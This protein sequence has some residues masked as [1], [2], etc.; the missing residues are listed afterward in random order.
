MEETA[1]I[2]HGLSPAEVLRS[3]NKFGFNVE[4]THDFTTLKLIIRTLFSVFNIVMLCLIIILIVIGESSIAK[5]IGI[6]AG[7][8]TLIGLVQEI[9]ARLIVKKLNKLSEKTTK[10]V[11]ENKITE[12]PVKELVIGDVIHLS[13]GDRVPVDGE[14]ISA[15]YAEFDESILTGES[16]YVEKKKNDEIK[17]GSFA[18]A[19]SCN[20]TM[21]KFT[22]DSYIQTLTKQITSQGI[23]ES[24][25][26]S[27]MNDIIKAL[28][29]MTI[30]FIA[31][32]VAEGF[33]QE[34]QIQEIIINAST[35]VSSL[36]P[37]GLVLITTIS[38]AY[39]AIKMA[40]NQAIIQNLSS[41]ES[42]ANAK[43]VCMDKTGTLT[44]NVLQVKDITWIKK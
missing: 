27:Q 10:V 35:L 21:T 29:Y 37:Q 31:L 26:Q 6:I 4:K 14:V 39:G 2:P 12:I 19:G 28:T 30:F 23:T 18:A 11:R 24:P 22:R 16:Q 13:S 38:F 9:R 17:A 40:Q 34:K 42:M 5:F 15:E 7:I 32:L 3:R 44:E 1:S 43:V 25:L 36:V 33:V 41:I 8:N 20:Y